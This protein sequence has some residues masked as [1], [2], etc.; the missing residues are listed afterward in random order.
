MSERV[1]AVIDG[2]SLMHRAFHA[3]QHPMNA[4][5]G[6]PT[7]AC[8]GFI[9]MLLKLVGD[10]KPSGVIAA[11]DAGIPASR[12]EAIQEYKAQRPPTDP[13]LKA[14]F[15]MI[16][17]L[18][19]SLNIPVVRVQDFEGDDILGTL[20]LMAEEQGNI[21][22]LL[23]TGDKDALQLASDKTVIVTNRTG[24]SEVTIYD[25]A[26]VYERF[27]VEPVQVPDFLGL[28]GDSSDNIP[29]IP[30]VGPKTATKLLQDYGS[31]ENVLAH[32]G[33]LKGKLAEKVAEGAQKALDS[34]QV[35]TIIRDVPLTIDF[36]TVEFPN[37]D[38]TEVKR[39]FGELGMMSQLRKLLR[40][41]GKNADDIPAPTISRPPLVV[42]Q[43]ESGT[44]GTGFGVPL[45]IESGTPNP[46]PPVPP[47]PVPPV[48]LSPFPVT[49]SLE[50]LGESEQ[51]GLY[52]NASDANASAKTKSAQQSLLLDDVEEQEKALYIATENSTIVV[53][54]EEVPGA[55]KSLLLSKHSLACYNLKGLLALLA[56][57]DTSED[58]LL[59]SAE[60]LN[61]KAFD[62]S[63]ASYLLD[64]DRPMNDPAAFVERFFPEV[65]LEKLQQEEAESKDKGSRYAATLAA[66]ARAIAPHLKDELTATEAL[67]CYEQIEQPLTSV[68]V[69]MERSGVLVDTKVLAEQGKTLTARIEELQKQALEMAGTEFNL[70]SPKQVGEILFE[71]LQLPT[72]KKTK[73]GY[74]TDASV[75]ADLKSHSPLPG[76]ILDYRE[77]AKLRSTYIEALPRLVAEDGLIHTSFNQTVTATGRLSS[78]DPNLQNIPVRTDIGKHIRTA[79]VAD[80][81]ALGVEQAVFVSADYSQIELRLLAHLSGDEHL[82]AAFV[83]GED[84]HRETAARVF[85]IK[86]E[87]VTPQMR[88]RAKAVNFGIVYGQQAFGLAQSL[89]IG[90]AEAGQMIKRYFEAY[91][92]V[93]EY[94]ESL[95]AQA[96]TQGWVET[97]FGRRRQIREIASRIP[98]R[99]NFAERTAMNHPMQGSAADIVKLAMNRIALKL[100]EEGYRSKMVLQVHDELDFN[101]DTSELEKLSSMV[102]ATMQDVVTLK[103]PLMVEV[104]SGPNWAEA[105]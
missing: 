77:L 61:C 78:S 33:D 74:S 94:L 52:L 73:S 103:V 17:E 12:F 91:P 48:P 19:K 46:V 40:L 2:N 20:S 31:L 3:V 10:F 25:P 54:G 58:A 5:D 79:F 105:H 18:L 14:Q 76:I 4:P 34:R 66:A 6:R 23:I 72:G 68:L 26:G 27:G 89:G 13:E 8:F 90:F 43:G 11:F 70:D 50:K 57:P 55:L 65:D 85:G 87:D 1:I 101:C 45:S 28:M 49:H 30:G 53:S 60:L 42:V 86:S 16:E 104:S 84:F 59:T 24:M 32:A 82:I 64:S 98:A 22:T 102:T 69:Q 62:L 7:N 41:T 71:K 36:D 100:E 80:P 92:Q 81:Q 96:H 21:K 29:G 15:P 97:I 47:N 44:G 67:N 37:F 95:K 9:A 38:S 35:A 93:H 75:L 88:G 51:L 99:R 83:H 56:P 39:A 63:V